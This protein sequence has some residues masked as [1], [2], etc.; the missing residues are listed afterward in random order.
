MKGREI[1]TIPWPDPVIIEDGNYFRIDG[2][3]WDA[4]ALEYTVRGSK[5]TR[6]SFP[7]GDPARGPRDFELGDIAER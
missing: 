3:P 5:S 7:A 2:L 4:F 1:G 6:V